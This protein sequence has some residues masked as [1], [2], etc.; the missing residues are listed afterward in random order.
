MCNLLLPSL[1]IRE[2]APVP[3]PLLSH[4]ESAACLSDEFNLAGHQP[5]LV[6]VVRPEP[7]RAESPPGNDLLNPICV[8]HC[9]RQVGIGLKERRFTS[10]SRTL[11]SCLQRQLCG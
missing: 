11:T 3:Q 7:T 5:C 4:P 9:R 6:G 1:L 8:E 10:V 2:S